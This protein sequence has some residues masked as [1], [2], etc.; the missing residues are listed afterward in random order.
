MTEETDSEPRLQRVTTGIPE[1][2]ARQHAS[3]TRHGPAS[4]RAAAWAW[5]D[6]RLALANRLVVQFHEDQR[7]AWP[8][9]LAWPDDQVAELERKLDGDTWLPEWQ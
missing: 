6:R 9:I 4:A 3:G 7:P 8:H 1:A 2:G 5:Y